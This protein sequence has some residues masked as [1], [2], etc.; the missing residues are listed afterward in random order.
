LSI[1]EIRALRGLIVPV[2]EEIK[3]DWIKLR[4]EE[5]S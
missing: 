3:R 2:G 5:L 1:I 4:K